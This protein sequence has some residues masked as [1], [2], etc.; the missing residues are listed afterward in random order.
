MTIASI[1]E[2][3]ARIRARLRLTAARFNSSWSLFFVGD[4]VV[5]APP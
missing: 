1:A 3:R 5:F 4:A 2:R